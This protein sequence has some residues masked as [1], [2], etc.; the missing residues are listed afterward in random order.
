MLELQTSQDF[1]KA[2]KSSSD[3]PVPNEPTKIEIART[4]W[5]NSSFYAPRKGE[6]IADWSF[7]V[8]IEGKGPAK[9]SLLD[10]RFWRL[11]LDV[12]STSDPLPSSSWLPAILSRT[13]LIP[14]VVSL[15]ETLCKVDLVVHSEVLTLVRPCLAILWPISTQKMTTE[16]LLD[17]FASFLRFMKSRSQELDINPNHVGL[18][19]VTSFR[20]SFATCSTKKKIF[21]TFVR[22]VLPDWVLSCEATSAQHK[23]SVSRLIYASGI[24]CLFN[25]EILRDS[26]LE[27]TF[28]EA[29]GKV[30]PEVIMPFLPCLYQSHVESIKKNRG[31]LFAQDSK[32]RLDPLNEFRNS[33]LRVF[34]SYHVILSEDKLTQHPISVWRTRSAL[35]DLVDQYHLYNGHG[36]GQQDQN[37]TGFFIEKIIQTVLFELGAGETEKTGVVLECLASLVQIDY[38]LIEEVLPD[39]LLRLLFISHAVASSFT[40]LELLLQYH[41]KTR[42]IDTYIEKVLSVCSSLDSVTGDSKTAFERCSGS[43]LLHPAHLDKVAKAA[44]DFLPSTQTSNVVHS[45]IAT[46]ESLQQQVLS[47]GDSG[48]SLKKRK[49]NS[50]RKESSQVTQVEVLRL[51]ATASVALV[52]LSS[53]SVQAVA[54][55]TRIQLLEALRLFKTS[56]NPALLRSLRTLSAEQDRNVEIF[57]SSLLRLRYAIDLQLAEF[58]DGLPDMDQDLRDAMKEFLDSVSM[59]SCPDL[60]LEVIRTLLTRT[61]DEAQDSALVDQV[62]ES[63]DGDPP[64]DTAFLL[65]HMLVHR[66]LSVIDFRASGQ[67]LQK[68][69]GILLDLHTRHEAPYPL[70]MLVSQLLSMADFWELP[71]LRVALLSR[72]DGATAVLDGLESQQSRLEIASVE[73]QN[74]ISAFNLLLVAPAE[75]LTSSSVDSKAGTLDVPATLYV[76]RGFISRVLDSLDWTDSLYR[77][78]LSRLQHL[79]KDL[80]CS[81]DT[82]YVSVTVGLAEL[83]IAALLKQGEKDGS[84]LVVLIATFQNAR[85]SSGVTWNCFNR[86]VDILQK[87]YTASQFPE[88][89]QIA[90][91]DLSKHLKSALLPQ[92]H[93]LADTTPAEGSPSS[94]TLL[95]TWNRLQVLQRWQGIKEE[96]APAFGRHL[97]IQMSRRS[98]TN[99]ELCIHAFD[100]LLEDFHETHADNRADQLD[101]VVAVY[102][103]LFKTRG[104]NVTEHIDRSVLAFY[105][106]L[107]VEDFT[108]AV[109]FVCES[110]MEVDEE[111]AEVAP[112]VHLATL[113]MR[114]PPQSSSQVVQNLIL[115]CINAFNARDFFTSGTSSVRLTVLDF[116]LARCRDKPATLRL[117]ELG[118]IWS[119]IAKMTCGSEIHDPTTSFKTLHSVI[120]IASSLIRLRRDLVVLTIPHLGTI[121]R[122]LILIMKSPRTNLGARQSAI[123]SND[124]PVWVRPHQPF[125]VEEGKALARLLESLTT[126]TVPRTHVVS[127]SSQTPKAESLAKPFSKHAAYVLKAYIQL[128]N[129]PLCTLP[130][131][132]RKEL[133]PGLYALCGTMNDYSRDALMASMAEAGDKTTLKQLWQD[134]EKQKY[135]GK[136]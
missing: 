4:T 7:G 52:V 53:V 47:P 96:S 120:S 39:I 74:V 56:L 83:Y 15:L 29:L 93:A 84:E 86:M 89:V 79:Q 8:V 20:R 43:A 131:N 63:L 113:L 75:Y 82:Q 133:Q 65:L 118:G 126:K 13:P 55:S 112:L 125:G 38:R 22:T 44:N 128:V 42:T 90:F 78:A 95:T 124:L 26:K 24:E 30:D 54:E 130:V 34:E 111:S 87:E 103:L 33:A 98:D 117:L 17:C 6:I 101:V 122:R 119:L 67:Q 71:R 25:L 10:T 85:P 49:L 102:I 100:I 92:I 37:G 61:P 21:S 99:D 108:H 66:W 77:D 68:L 28:F 127:S 81:E 69:V 40:L 1:V 27:D 60:T 11:L 45:S 94:S 105:S 135:V 62:L 88:V 107:T 134:Y 32:N 5:D 121:L 35:L 129:D 3:P 80:P 12:I 46:I 73:A 106:S 58:S 115:T 110:L 72:I 31:A 50:G 23:H 123:V 109:N 104:T 14:I 19:I 2:L 57:T 48:T 16:A 18:F 76:V 70:K 132:V 36:L 59:R 136:G 91:V 51:F 41:T 64:P 114:E 97:T 9:T 116:L